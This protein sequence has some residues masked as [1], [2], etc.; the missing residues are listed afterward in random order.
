MSDS[1]L[2]ETAELRR[3]LLQTAWPRLSPEPNRSKC[4]TEAVNLQSDGSSPTSFRAWSGARTTPRGSRPDR[5][6]SWASRSPLLSTHTAWWNERLLGQL[7]VG[8]ASEVRQL[9]VAR[10]GS[11][12]PQ[13]G[14]EEVEGAL[15]HARAHARSFGDERLAELGLLPGHLP[16]EQALAST[17]AVE[18]TTA[19]QGRAGPRRSA[20]PTPHMELGP[21]KK[22]MD[23]LSHGHVRNVHE[24]T[25]VK[26]MLCGIDRVDAK[27]RFYRGSKGTAL[28]KHIEH[29]FMTQETYTGREMVNV[30][31]L[32]CRSRASPSPQPGQATLAHGSREHAAPEHLRYQ[33]ASRLKDAGSFPAVEPRVALAAQRSKHT[34][35]QAR[36][37]EM[38]MEG[39][40]QHFLKLEQKLLR[41]DIANRGRRWL[42]ALVQRVVIAG[43]HAIVETFHQQLLDA[44]RAALHQKSG[45]LLRSGR[46]LWAL[47]LKR[48]GGSGSRLL[49]PLHLS[50][51]QKLVLKR[52]YDELSTCRRNVAAHKWAKTL[53]LMLFVVRIR[54]PYRKH[55]AAEAVKNFVAKTWRG[56]L[57][58]R[59]IKSFYSRV[60]FIQAS[61]RASNELFAFVQERII[62]PKVWAMETLIIGEKLGINKDLMEGVIAAHQPPCSGEHWRPQF[63]RLVEQRT[64]R[65]FMKTEAQQAAGR[66][67]KTRSTQR[68]RSVRSMLRPRG[69]DEYFRAESPVPPVR[70]PM[71]STGPRLETPTSPES[72]RRNPRSPCRAKE[73]A[74]Q[75]PRSMIGMGAAALLDSYRLTADARKE[76]GAEVLRSNIEVW[77]KAYKAY[78]IALE[79]SH[80]QWRDWRSDIKS[81]GEHNRDLWPEQPQH[82]IYPMEITKVSSS[83][84]KHLLLQHLGEGRAATLL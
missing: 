19:V 76:I 3:A 27:V 81:L 58:R 28:V 4:R 56:C 26:S 43:L 34:E 6:G 49:R 31:R 5:P 63:N 33:A 61:L 82:C 60:R 22:A 20:T 44:K 9:E 30:A 37:R 66:V 8:Q 29:D 75:G 45:R 10:Q 70:T 79:H 36:M 74:H 1:D 51:I 78:K 7:D 16:A 52:R 24:V 67:K 35:R 68:V 38:Q 15:F 64:F 32:R 42:A 48:I 11:L 18:A 46:Q 57:V 65:H 17:L 62:E 59:T 2:G 13:L 71:S 69:L 77:W 53:R 25:E 84:L 21:K 41:S 80:Q 73:G 72:P 55:L 12:S 14:F 40:V 39:R 54:R 50:A 83:H 23:A 47:A